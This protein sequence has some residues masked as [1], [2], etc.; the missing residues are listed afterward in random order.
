MTLVMRVA[1]P[2]S[3]MT[4]RI[5]TLKAPVPVT[6]PGMTSTMPGKAAVP[7]VRPQQ[8]S[9]KNPNQNGRH[10][11]HEE[12]QKMR[13]IMEVKTLILMIHWVIVRARLS[14]VQELQVLLL[15]HGHCYSLHCQCSYAGWDTAWLRYIL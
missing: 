9:I 5:V 8:L 3:A 1:E 7:A 12:M 13:L 4:T 14:G 2:L 15:P 11:K 6:D 10:G